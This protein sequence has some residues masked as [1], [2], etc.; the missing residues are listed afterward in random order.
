MKSGGGLVIHDL[1]NLLGAT[2]S[3]SLLGLLV[4]E[5]WAA[6]L[7]STE[8]TPSSTEVAPPTFE[9]SEAGGATL[10][11]E[12]VGS[13]DAGDAAWDTTGLGDQETQETPAGG[14]GSRLS[15]SWMTSPP[16]DFTCSRL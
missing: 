14:G 10:V 11:K 6:S 9:A 8:P 4:P 15:R 16:P 12:G 3:W 7:A 13:A 1:D 5:S 2:T